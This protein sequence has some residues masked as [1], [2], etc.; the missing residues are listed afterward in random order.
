MTDPQQPLWW[1]I[2]KQIKSRTPSFENYCSHQKLLE[3]SARVRKWNG[4]VPQEVQ[5]APKV[6]PTPGQNNIRH[7]IFYFFDRIILSTK[8]DATM[9]VPRICTGKQQFQ[10][11]SLCHTVEVPNSSSVS[12]SN[13]SL[14]ECT[15]LRC[16]RS[17]VQTPTGTCLSR[18][19]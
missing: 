13:S 7:F 2:V 15:G 5:D 12:C 3:F 16:R 18:V 1:R 9:L 11:R 8:E 17:E 10:C 14:L 19:L 6:F 4:T